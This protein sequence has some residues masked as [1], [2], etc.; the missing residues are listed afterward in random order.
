M[1]V[2]EMVILDFGAG[3]G[4][5]LSCGAYGFKTR[6]M[7]LRGKVARVIACDVDEVVLENPGADETVVIQPDVELPFA[8][9]TFDLIVA[10]YVFEHIADPVLVSAELRRILRPGGWMCARTPNKY[11]LISL[12]TRMIRNT[13]HKRVLRWAQPER[14]SIDVFPTVFKLNSRRAI[15]N[16]FIPEAFDNF[17]YGYEAQLSYFF[18][19][20]SVF[21]LILLLNRLTPPGMKSGLF[22]FLRKK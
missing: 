20:R 19:S 14:Q 22:V 21:A 5:A 11:C 1:L 3:R 6:L 2:P 16:I 9:G 4:A 12:L 7:T 13:Q 10:D 18:N 8:D 17:T 15:A